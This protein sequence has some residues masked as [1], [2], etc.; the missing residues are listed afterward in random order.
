MMHLYE[1]GNAIQSSTP[2]EQEDV[3]QVVAIAKREMPQALLKNLQT[4]IGSAG[5][6]QDAQ[7]KGIPSGDIDL[8]VEAADVV[9]VFQTQDNPKDPVL[10]AKKAMQTFFTAKGIEANVNGRNVSIGVKYKTAQGAVKIAQ[11]DLMVIH[12]AKLVA[13]YHQHGLRDMYKDP[14]FKGQANFVL[15]SSLAKAEN[16]KFDPFGAKLVRRDTGDVVARS[17]DEVAKVLIGGSAKA[18]DLYSVKSMIAALQKYDDTDT[19]NR[20]LAQARD[21]AAKGLI[22]LPETAPGVG[23]AAWFRHLGHQL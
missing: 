10:A 13:P 19:I 1:G 20:K 12:D 6:K 18:K 4:D 22:T 17:M 9:A 3:P 23:T 14:T 8:M 15:I 21:D 2:V 7:G 5:Y 16:L 11:V